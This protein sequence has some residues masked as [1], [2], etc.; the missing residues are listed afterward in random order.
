MQIQHQLRAAIRDRRLAARERLP[1]TRRLADVLGISRGTIV[2]VY[3]Q[4]VAEGYLE[5]AVGS[6]TRVAEMPDGGP[7]RQSF[8]VLA[9]SASP[10]PR[11]WRGEQDARARRPTGLGSRTAAIRAGDSRGEATQQS[12]S[13]WIRPGGARAAHGDRQIRPTPASDAGDPLPPAL[14]LGFGNVSQHQISLGIRT[15]AEALQK[16]TTVPSG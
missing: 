11:P 9:T 15:L 5:A 2:D 8:P 12:R 4:L 1:S 16:Q 14:V 7:A 6:G 13:P 3:D 10:P